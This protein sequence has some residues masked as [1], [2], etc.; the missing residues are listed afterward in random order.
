LAEARLATCAGRSPGPEGFDGLRDLPCNIGEGFIAVWPR[1]HWFAIAR[2]R[3]QLSKGRALPHA[4]PKDDRDDT[5]LAGP[6][7][8]HRSHHLRE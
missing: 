6:V 1:R 5:S 8:L 2:S 3:H 7:S 4:V